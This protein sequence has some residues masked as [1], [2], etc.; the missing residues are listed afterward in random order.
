MIRILHT[1]D[2][3]LGKKLEHISRLAEQAE[4]MNEICDIA[5]RENPDLVIVAGDLYDQFNPPIEA[6]DLLYKTLKR[7]SADGK[8]P[9]LAI[10]GNHDSPDRI[11]SVDPLARYN[12]I[13]F[14]GYP[15]SQIPITKSGKGWEISKTGEGF[16]EFVWE[17][18]DFP[19][20]VLH[21]AFANEFR[22]R[23]DLGNPD[24]NNM[25]K[26]LSNHW[27]NLV[28]THCSDPGIQILT[29]HLFASQERASYEEGEGERATLAIGG[30]QVVFPDQF[31]DKINYVALGH[32]HRPHAISSA[33]PHIHYSGSP[34][35][36][37]FAE[38]GQQKCVNL[39]ELAPDQPA[40]ITRV[41]LESG[42]KLLRY[43]AASVADALE[44]LANNP[45]A[46]VDLTIRVD[47]YLEPAD[48]RALMNANPLIFI[49]PLSQEM[50]NDHGGTEA[51]Y[52]SGN[53]EDHFRQF[54]EEKTGQA[55]TEDLRNLFKEILAADPNL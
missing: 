2:W 4:V 28:Q 7:L 52:N 25:A 22:L 1:A 55:P 47:Q 19:V 20:R 42:K 36:Y 34:L 14:S 30:A 49:R 54:F 6:Q 16:V 9:V 17:K 35:A 31:P 12:G 21:T 46:I 27:E 48:R 53:I 51:R 24:D 15:Y 18:L 10:A 8:R 32:L 5:G 43:E 50:R 3:H 40:T 33:T 23:K 38:A 26:L 29:A 45:G 41:N 44:Y 11:A 13:F 37:S 39:V